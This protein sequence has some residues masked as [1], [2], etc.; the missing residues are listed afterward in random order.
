MAQTPLFIAD[1]IY[2]S[3]LRYDLWAKKFDK[4]YDTGL[5]S[6]LLSILNVDLK[7]INPKDLTALFK[8]EGIERIRKINIEE[9]TN[10]KELIAKWYDIVFV[11][12]RKLVGA[13]VKNTTIKY[14]EL[15]DI[16][17]NFQYLVRHI[18]LIKLGRQLFKNELDDIFKRI[19]PIVLIMTTAY[20]QHQLLKEMAGVFSSKKCQEE[21]SMPLEQ[22]IAA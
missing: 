17:D 7:K 9:I 22:Q 16:T 2:E 12:D 1:D 13:N 10:N 14:R 15:Y 6:L 8:P 21:F 19:K 5:V 3:K 4:T 18:A 11:F 20:W